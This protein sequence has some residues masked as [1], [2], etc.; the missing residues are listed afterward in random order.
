MRRDEDNGWI[1]LVFVLI[2]ALSFGVDVWWNA[3]VYG[4]WTCAFSKCVRVKP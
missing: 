2:V 4:D 3:H 1:V